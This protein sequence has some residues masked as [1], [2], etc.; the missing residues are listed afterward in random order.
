MFHFKHFQKTIIHQLLYTK[1]I[2][3]KKLSQIISL[4]LMQT[5]KYT[6]KNRIQD[7]DIFRK[8][9]SKLNEIVSV[10]LLCV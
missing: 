2:R 6:Q 9:F 4:I 1:C 8:K 5:K 10:S 7:M 3:K